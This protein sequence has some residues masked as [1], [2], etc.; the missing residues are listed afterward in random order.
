[1]AFE[2]IRKEKYLS[3]VTRRKSGEEVATPMWFLVEG[4]RVYMRTGAASAKVKRIRHTPEVWLAPCTAGGR[5]TGPRFG[6]VARVGDPVLMG[7]VNSGLK[8]KYGLAKRI[9]DLVN[10]LRGAR[11]IVVLEITLGE[12]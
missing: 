3:L 4:D 2:P 12:R 10:R 8:Q 11:E 1:V 7:P 9:I 5:E 6:A